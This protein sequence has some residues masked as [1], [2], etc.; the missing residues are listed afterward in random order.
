[1]TENLLFTRNPLLVH[2]AW[3]YNEVRTKCDWVKRIDWDPQLWL[4]WAFAQGALVIVVR[5]Q[6]KRLFPLTGLIYRGGD[7]AANP[8]FVSDLYS[9]PGGPDV[10]VDFCSGSY[11]HAFSFFALLKPRKIGWCRQGT[12]KVH[13]RQFSKMPRH[14]FTPIPYNNHEPPTLAD[15]PS[16]EP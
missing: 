8:L 3:F 4:W 2:F 14:P 12:D 9:N 1:M 6:G 11:Q 15:C 16:I 5:Q 10:W 13:I 7:F